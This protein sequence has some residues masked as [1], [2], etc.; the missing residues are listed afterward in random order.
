MIQDHTLQ[1]EKYSSIAL[2]GD[3]LTRAECREVLATP[4]SEILG[5]LHAAYEV[6]KQFAGNTVQVQMLT[7][8][9]SGA[10][11]EDCHYCSQSSISTADIEHYGLVP[12]DCWLHHCR[13]LKT[14]EVSCAAPNT[15]TPIWP[16]RLF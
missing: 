2:S 8:A 4:D 14:V 7:N 5:L 1:F 6:R 12:E 10:C 15:W 11:I 13:V 3:V 16:S 9:K